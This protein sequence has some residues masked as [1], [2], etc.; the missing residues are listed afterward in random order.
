MQCGIIYP[1]SSI[2]EILIVAIFSFRF[3]QS[4][5]TNHT[6]NRSLRRDLLLHRIFGLAFDKFA[7]SIAFL[8][9]F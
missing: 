1:Q 4:T 7:R 5:T 6:R 2:P 8:E 3:L 9:S